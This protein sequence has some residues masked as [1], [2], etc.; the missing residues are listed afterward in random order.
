MANPGFITQAQREAA[1]EKGASLVLKAL[2]DCKFQ[3][4]IEAMADAMLQTVCFLMSSV[5]E[6]EPLAVASMARTHAKKGLDKRAEYDPNAETV[7]KG[8]A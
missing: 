8:K 4:E 6:R 1:R 5:M 7:R 3:G 2:A